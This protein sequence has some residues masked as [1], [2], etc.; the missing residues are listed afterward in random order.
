MPRVA[1][2][3]RRNQLLD[4]LI[5]AVATGGIGGRSLREIGAAA[6]T[7]SKSVSVCDMIV[8]ETVTAESTLVN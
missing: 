7:I 4:A 6:G 3:E 2:D 5:N 1:D 8:S